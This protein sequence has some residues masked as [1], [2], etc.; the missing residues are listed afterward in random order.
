[1]E[2]L[3][4]NTHFIHGLQLLK[5]AVFIFC[6]SIFLT[7]QIAAFAQ[8]TVASP[9]TSIDDQLE[10][11]ESVEITQLIFEKE[12]LQDDIA[13]VRRSLNGQLAEYRLAEQDF[14]IK[15]GQFEQ[16]N[17]LSSL[18]AAVQSTREV[19]AKRAQVLQSYLTLL[20][21]EVLN[22][23]GLR[24]E[25]REFALDQN[26]QLE[27]ELEDHLSQLEA[28]VDRDSI[29]I[30]TGNFELLAP[31]IQEHIGFTR[32]ILQLARY[33]SVFDATE[34]LVNR[35]LDDSNDP[36]NPDSIIST[37]QDRR[38]VEQIVNALDTVDVALSDSDDQIATYINPES[39]RRQISIG[40]N[41]ETAYGGMRQ[42]FRFLNELVTNVK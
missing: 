16:L 6:I 17:T 32:Q 21:L 24:L 42:V 14:I 10:M 15:K 33:Q 13:E 20:R 23:S 22:S 41:I 1:M 5:G 30:T 40:D 35:I 9:S 26:E 27:L 2:V 34:A 29:R 8:T 36:N 3:T 11:S 18:E 37:A 31:K 38:A 12:E 28:S 39:R 19:M 4:R 7:T 25:Y